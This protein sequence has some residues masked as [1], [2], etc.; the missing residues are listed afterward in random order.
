MHF[1][2]GTASGDGRALEAAQKAVSSP[3]L[4]D[5]AIGGAEA[6]LV[7][8]QGGPGMGFHEAAQAAQFVSD[9]V[10]EE[11]DVFWGAVVDPHMDDEIRVTLVA[12]GFPETKAQET[13]DVRTQQSAART[14][15]AS[16]QE[17]ASHGETADLREERAV[18]PEDWAELLPE[19]E[20]VPRAG[21]GDGHGRDDWSRDERARDD[22]A[23]SDHDGRG[24]DGQ[25]RAEHR[26]DRAQG[27]QDATAAVGMART[28]TPTA[29]PKTGW[30]ARAAASTAMPRGR[31]RTE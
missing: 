20:F 11:A 7:N 2:S 10:G 17:R 19:E 30:R 1:G 31:R 24:H 12:T 16:A 6:V 4:E 21:N 18:E 13:I 15:G 3:L 27:V 25:G 22:R 23:W 9:Q 28:T 14:G 29:A 8:I 26:G 5:L